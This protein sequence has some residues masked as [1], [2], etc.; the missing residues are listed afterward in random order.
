[1]KKFR[2][3]RVAFFLLAPLFRTL[4]P[5]AERKRQAL[6]TVTRRFASASPLPGEAP[7]GFAKPTHS[8]VEKTKSKSPLLAE[9]GE[10]EQTAEI[11]F[12][13]RY[14]GTRHSSM[15]PVVR[16]QGD[17]PQF[18][19]VVPRHRRNSLSALSSQ[20]D[21]PLKVMCRGTTGQPD[22]S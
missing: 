4:I 3:L 7:E 9:T 6:R 1:M 10:R 18:N 11:L 8:A 22:K 16:Y 5:D 19:C 21:V 2:S 13:V 17:P 12:A 15:R 20:R 14:G